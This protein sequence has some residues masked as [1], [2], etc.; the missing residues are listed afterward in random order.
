[1]PLLHNSFTNPFFITITTLFNA[2]VFLFWFLPL[3]AL[4]AYKKQYFAASLLFFGLACVQVIKTILKYLTDSPRPENIFDIS[5][6]G[7][8]FPS[9]H[10]ATGVFFFIAL[11]YLLTPYMATIGKS[12]R[13]AIQTSL[14]FGMIAVPFSR[15][16]TQVHYMSDVIAGVLLGILSFALTLFV[17]TKLKNTYGY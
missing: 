7:S 11:Y 3:L 8:S 14:V 6:H 17:L 10:A 9:G 5:V 16:F 13:R 15:L 4:L 2:E 1:M 12:W